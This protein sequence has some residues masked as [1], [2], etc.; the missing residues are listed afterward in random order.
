MQGL[1]PCILGVYIMIRLSMLDIHKL[2]CVL[3]KHGGGYRIE[4]EDGTIV[5][6][7]IDDCGEFIIDGI[8]YEAK[9]YIY[10]KIYKPLTK[11]ALYSLLVNLL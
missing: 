11:K 4:L 1:K 2:F 6:D 7:I 9:A 10:I 3:L 5:N 8:R